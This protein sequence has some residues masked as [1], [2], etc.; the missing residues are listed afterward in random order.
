MLKL[1]AF[2]AGLILLFAGLAAAYFYYQMSRPL[3]EVGT[4]RV[5]RDLAAPLEPPERATG[6]DEFWDVGK[7]IRLRHFEEGQGNPVLVVHG[8]PGIPFSEPVPGLT[9]LADR[10]RFVYYDQRGSGASTRPIDTF[11]SGG[12]YRNMTTL[13]RQLGLAAQIADM[14]RIR[15]ILGEEKLTIVGHSFGAF[16]ASLYAA[17]FPDH[18]NA[19]ILIAPA[20]VL[21]MPNPDGDL[22]DAV[23]D[24]LPEDMKPAFTDYRNRLF[25]FSDVFSRSDADIVALN[26]E[27]LP[28]YAAAVESRGLTL[29]EMAASSQAGGWMTFG[30]YMSMGRKAD[31][32]PSLA[33]VSA[34]VLVI[35]A[36]NDLQPEMASRRYAEA[37]PNAEFTTIE[38][39][40]HF[41]FFEQPEAF[42]QVVG[43]FLEAQLDG[44]SSSD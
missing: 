27:F 43:V 2:V 31:W 7:G 36:E 42:S 13:N 32:R 14:E 39:S 23:G 41:P 5:E 15:R 22:Y 24:A 16:I 12:F 21:V 25:D 28:F 11:D 18:V 40:G 17:E 19:L 34:P 10:Y 1:L 4:V 29:P 35:H 6:T 26:A 44:L 33:S 8:G 9:T 3:Y 30:L 20:D 38:N 37:F